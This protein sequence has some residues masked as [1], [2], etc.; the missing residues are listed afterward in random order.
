MRHINVSINQKVLHQIFQNKR[1]I[2]K[3]ISENT[4]KTLK[5]LS[6]VIEMKYKSKKLPENRQSPEAIQV[7]LDMSHM[8][9]S[10]FASCVDLV[11]PSSLHCSQAQVPEDSQDLLLLGRVPLPGGVSLQRERAM[12]VLP[13]G[14]ISS[15]GEET[16][17]QGLFQAPQLPTKHL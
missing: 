5:V 7:Q 6:N 4:L 14:A 10:R 9:S 15:S 16:A 12:Q 1:H 11:L 8:R 17:I 3:D 13:C 2:T